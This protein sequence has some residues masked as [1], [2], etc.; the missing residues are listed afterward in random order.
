MAQSLSAG[1]NRLRKNS[2]LI[3]WIGLFLG[4]LQAISLRELP[5]IQD[6]DSMLSVLNVLYTIAFLGDFGGM[7]YAWR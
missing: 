5:E 3:F 2:A 4:C 6:R 7:K 1:Q